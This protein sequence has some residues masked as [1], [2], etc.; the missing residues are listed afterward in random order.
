V[1]QEQM[2]CRSRGPSLG[3]LRPVTAQVT[4]QKYEEESLR[5]AR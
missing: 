3:K 4:A 1:L 5:C 2:C